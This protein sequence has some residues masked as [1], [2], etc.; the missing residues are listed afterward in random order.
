[1]S[2]FWGYGS[3]GHNDFFRHRRAI[4]GTQILGSAT[5][6]TQVARELYEWAWVEMGALSVYCFAGDPERNLNNGFVRW[7]FQNAQ[8]H[9]R[10]MLLMSEVQAWL[11]ATNGDSISAFT[12][13]ADPL[14]HNTTEYDSM[15]VPCLTVRTVPFNNNRERDNWWKNVAKAM[16]LVSTFTEKNKGAN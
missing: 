14:Y 4:F 8:D 5:A 7:I 1:M 2:G 3:E 13:D 6:D 10:F 16:Q 11:K 12:L 9:T 15:G